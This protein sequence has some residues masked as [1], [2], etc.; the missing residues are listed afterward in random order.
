LLSFRKTKYAEIAKEHRKQ[1][2]DMLGKLDASIAAAVITHIPVE[3]STPE[4]NKRKQDDQGGG[5]A[6]KKLVAT[7]KHP[8][9]S[10]STLYMSTE[11]REEA[12]IEDLKEAI[13]IHGGTYRLG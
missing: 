9:K 4:L 1:V 11:E 7:P 10:K 5:S 12:A 2:K 3:D 13:R 8:D 6:K